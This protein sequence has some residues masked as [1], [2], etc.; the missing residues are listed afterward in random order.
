M[1]MDG[2]PLISTSSITG[3]FKYLIKMLMYDFDQN[4]MLF[5]K[6]VDRCRH[7]KMLRGCEHRVR[8]SNPPPSNLRTSAPL[9]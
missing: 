1:K 6:Q 4:V 7:V 2:N 8:V 5:P 3:N 9:P